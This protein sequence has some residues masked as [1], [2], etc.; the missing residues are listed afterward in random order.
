MMCAKIARCCLAHYHGD[1]VAKLAQ[2]QYISGGHPSQGQGHHA[3]GAHHG[4]TLNE[5]SSHGRSHVRDQLLLTFV[6]LCV[7]AQAALAFMTGE[8]LLLLWRTSSHP[9]VLDSL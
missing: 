2:H 1:G 6:C 7:L 8:L 3:L 4:H 9:L 5:D